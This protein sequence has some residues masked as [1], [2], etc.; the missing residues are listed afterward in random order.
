MRYFD[1]PL[2]TYSFRH[3]LVFQEGHVLTIVLH[4]PEKKNALNN[5]MV[6]ELALAFQ[7]ARTAESVWVVM[8]KAEGDIFCAGMD[9]RAPEE[10]SEA[11]PEPAHPIRLFELVYGLRKP[12]IGV[13]QAPVL[14][15][16]ILLL[17]GCT[18]VIVSEKAT[19]SLPEVRRGLFPFQVLDALVRIGCPERKVLDW[20]MRATVL[21]AGEAAR[22]GLVTEVTTQPGER[23]DELLTEYMALSPAAIRLGLAAYQ[24]SRKLGVKERQAYL[25]DQFQLIQKTEDAQEGIAAFAEKRS[26]VW[27]NR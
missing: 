1:L 11:L 21:S 2:E 20:C 3:L 18:Q 5:L 13:A 10:G 14:A 6:K 19:F 27:K 24:E 9:L 25:F 12:C 17:A 4:R 15:G 8:L 26:P 7:Y 22:L 16:G 23:A